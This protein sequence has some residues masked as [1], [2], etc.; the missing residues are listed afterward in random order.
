MPRR[1]GRRT[2]RASA[3]AVRVTSYRAAAPPSRAATPAGGSPLDRAAI[4]KQ[5]KVS[6]RASLLKTP[7]SKPICHGERPPAPLVR[8]PRVQDMRQRTGLAGPRA[9][10]LARRA[11]PPAAFQPAGPVHPVLFHLGA[12][13]RRRR[14]PENRAGRAVRRLES[15]RQPHRRNAP[16][17]RSRYSQSPHRSV[18]VRGGAAALPAL[19]AP[20]VF[21][22][23]S[24]YRSEN[25]RSRRSAVLCRPNRSRCTSC[26]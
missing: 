22:Q 9:I 6:R 26:T 2:S 17:Q 4:L 20:T 24:R 19:A 21:Y 14:R 5:A 18:A 7:A 12:A 16:V 11:P 1:L 8:R 15:Q 25:P 10:P 23:A 3:H 13:T